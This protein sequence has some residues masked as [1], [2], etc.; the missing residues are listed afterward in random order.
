[1]IEH[2]EHDASGIRCERHDTSKR[3]YFA[4]NLA[5][6]KTSNCRVT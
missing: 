3:I 6:G 2:F 4:N 5:F 1:L